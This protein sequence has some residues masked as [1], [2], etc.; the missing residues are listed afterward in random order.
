M[1]F[2]IVFFVEFSH[3]NPNKPYLQK[4]S[5]IALKINANLHSRCNLVPILLVIWSKLQ[6][7]KDILHAIR[8]KLWTLCSQVYNMRALSVPRKRFRPWPQV[9]QLGR[10]C[11][12]PSHRPPMMARQKSGKEKRMFLSWSSERLAVDVAMHWMP[13]ATSLRKIWMHGIL[14]LTLWSV[15]Y[16]GVVTY[17]LCGRNPRLDLQVMLI[18]LGSTSDRSIWFV[19]CWVA[20]C[21]AIVGITWSHPAANKAQSYTYVL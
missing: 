7:S 20:S 10:E 1:V 17:T 15:C 4:A 5:I 21:D 14:V 6:P 8:T 2:K 19:G 16:F 3:W 18:C 11:F 9:L 12:D 13:S